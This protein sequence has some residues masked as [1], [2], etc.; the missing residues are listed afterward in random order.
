MRGIWYL[1][2]NTVVILA[3][4]TDIIETLGVSLLNFSFLNFIYFDC[5]FLVSLSSKLAGEIDLVLF[6]GF[7]VSSVSVLEEDLDLSN[8]LDL[9]NTL[10]LF[11]S[12]LIDFFIFGLVCLWFVCFHITYHFFGHIFCYRDQ[13]LIG[14]HD[15]LAW[16]F[17]IVL[18]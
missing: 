2:G 14:R 4:W 12:L 18:I 7:I 17:L 10:P 15:P 16:Y 11:D 3:P 9:F 6:S 8:E 5:F 13:W 1:S